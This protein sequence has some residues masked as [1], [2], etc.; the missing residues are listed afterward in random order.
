M[1]N[2]ATYGI[3]QHEHKKVTPMCE[4][5]EYT[6]AVLTFWKVSDNNARVNGM[7]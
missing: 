1:F 6:R 7:S 5:D 4:T 2:F 3:D